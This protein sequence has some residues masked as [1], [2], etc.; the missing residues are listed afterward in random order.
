MADGVPVDLVVLAPTLAECSTKGWLQAASV[1]A[2]RL[3]SGEGLVYVLAPFLWRPRIKNLL[4]QAGLPT[5]L[6]IAHLPDWDANRYLMPLRA[7]PIQYACSNL[8]GIRSWTRELIRLALGVPGSTAMLTNLMPSIGMVARRSQAP[9]LFA[10]LFEHE[11]EGR[12]SGDAIVATSWR[13]QGGTVALHGFAGHDARPTAIAKV[14]LTPAAAFRAEEEGARLTRLGPAAR[15]A[16]VQVPQLLSVSRTAR[17]PVLLQ[18][19][20]SGRLV[21]LLLAAERNRLMEIVDR[22]ADWLGRWHRLTMT[23]TPLTSDLLNEELLGPAT[24]LAPNLQHGSEYVDWLTLHCA[25]NVGVPV[26][27]VATHNDLTMWNVVLDARATLGVVDWEAGRERALPLGDFFFGATDAV[28]AS[29]GYVDRLA[30]FKACFAPDG[31][32]ARAIAERQERVMRAIGL[33]P[34]IAEL[35]LHACWLQHAVNEHR[36]SSG[37]GSRPFLAI[38]QWLANRRSD[39]HSI[40]LERADN[41]RS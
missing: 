23:I 29:F 30:A 34:Q 24:V 20:V 32:Y 26:P 10:W 15:Q 27:L 22:L 4:S 33:S 28:A 6:S 9:P 41:G 36:A 21:S 14:A 13:G 39:H 2:A 18:S 8:M 12:H 31:R 5:V 19:A 38:V 16:G 17:S 7:A 11:T 37:R 1:S 25:R 35:S 3:V 40:Q